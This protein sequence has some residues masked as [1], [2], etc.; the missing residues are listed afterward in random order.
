MLRCQG[1]V[2]DARAWD[3]SECGGGHLP[4]GVS[5]VS[6]LWLTESVAPLEACHCV[7][8][9]GAGR[10]VTLGHVLNLRAAQVSS[11]NRAGVPLLG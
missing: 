9:S 6:E 8:A 11:E 7:Y 2:L 3:T 5:P 1:S 10:G 4:S